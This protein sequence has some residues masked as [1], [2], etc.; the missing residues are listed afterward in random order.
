MYER[1]KHT[2]ATLSRDPEN[3]VRPRETV[4]LITGVVIMYHACCG[5]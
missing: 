5:P 3:E 1:N 2:L 4:D